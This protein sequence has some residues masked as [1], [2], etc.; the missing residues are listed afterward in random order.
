M[1]NKVRRL[2]AFKQKEVNE[3][4]HHYVVKG[5]LEKWNDYRE[6]KIQAIAKFIRVMKR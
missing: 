1:H 5:Q 3:H 2:K 4:M 6:A